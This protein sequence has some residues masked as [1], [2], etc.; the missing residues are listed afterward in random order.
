MKKNLITLAFLPI[1]SQAGYVSIVSKGEVVYIHENLNIVEEKISY[2][3][4]VNHNTHYDC[5]YDIVE[6]DLYYSFTDTQNGT[7]KQDQTRVKTTEITYT[8]GSKETKTSNEYQ[9]L[10]ENVSNTITGT[11]LEKS[12]LDIQSFNNSLPTNYYSVSGFD[13]DVYPVYC[14]MDTNGGGWTR[15]DY[16]SLRSSELFNITYTNY[17][18]FAEDNFVN[19]KLVFGDYDQNL[20]NDA[21]V[22]IEYPFNY[23]EFYLKDY[24]IKSRNGVLEIRDNNLT[25]QRWDTPFRLY[26]VDDKTNP[27]HGD[28]AFG[29]TDNNTP[30]TSFVQEG[31]DVQTDGLI[32]FPN[33][34]IYNNGLS[35]NTFSIRAMESGQE[36]EDTYIWH[37]GYIFLR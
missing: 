34:K 6:D 11:H 18:G 24:K 26:T 28:V 29:T 5:A 10:N 8:N 12:C 19:D 14:D 30:T 27:A 7:C 17:L 9:T 37:E 3:N 20:G 13:D 2:S 4:W 36:N 35:S 22:H 25:N 1:I 21:I 33:G 31:V 23:Q 32:S 15:F 16:S